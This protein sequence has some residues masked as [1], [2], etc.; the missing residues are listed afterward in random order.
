MQMLV[1]GTPAAITVV[2][3][4]RA[5]KAAMLVAVYQT[6]SLWFRV[7]SFTTIHWLWLKE[8][9]CLKELGQHFVKP[10]F[11]IHQI[12]Y[13]SFEIIRRHRLQKCSK[14]GAGR[15]SGL[16][17]PLTWFR[18]GSQSHILWPSASLA[19]TLPPW[20]SAFHSRDTNVS[21]PKMNTTTSKAVTKL[22]LHLL[23]ENNPFSLT[24]WILD[25]TGQ[26]Q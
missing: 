6:L 2:L 17:A 13:H 24:T 19:R 20:R 18:Q 16:T 5:V 8:N 10:L 26:Y 25:Q 21:G 1:P 3:V 12:I 14:Y 9:K 15:L 4:T 23:K 11:C 7:I 22:I